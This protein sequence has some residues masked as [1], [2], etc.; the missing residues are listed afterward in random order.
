MKHIKVAWAFWKELVRTIGNL[1]A[2]I[3]LAF[4]YAVVML[5]FGVVVRCFSDPLHIKV[6]P[7]GWTDCSPAEND[8]RQARQQ[9]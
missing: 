4:T 9:G 3:I 1:Q 8:L 7:T 5:P 2:H 6:R